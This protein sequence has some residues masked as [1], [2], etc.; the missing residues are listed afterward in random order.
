M[1]F[2]SINPTHPR[3][4]PCNF[5]KKILRIGDFEK[6]SFFE[7]AIL[8]FFLLL[9]H[10]NQSK[11]LGHQEWVDILLIT[12]VSSQT[13]LPPNIS[14]ASV[15]CHFSMLIWPKICLILYP[16]LGNLR[17]NIALKWTRSS[18]ER[19]NKSFEK[20]AL[21]VLSFQFIYLLNKV[22]TFN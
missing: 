14:A 20:K 5:H 1:P 16:S 18:F 13:S 3:T 2:A 11:V 12:L 21:D 7:S 17:T 9:L 22:H 8:N 4:N 6:L 15:L 10:E 19:N